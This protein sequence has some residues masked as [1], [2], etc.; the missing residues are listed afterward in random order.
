[1][2][3]RNKRRNISRSSKGGFLRKFF[4]FLLVLLI[5]TA[6]VAGFIL[7][8]TEKPTL[9]PTKKITYLGKRVELP[10]EASDFKS[11]L[12]SLEVTLEQKGKISRLFNRS[13]QR[14]SWFKDAGPKSMSETLVID[15]GGTGFDEGNASLVIRVRDFSLNGMFQGNETVHTIPVVI[16]TKAPKVS[17]IHSQQYIRPGS[18]GIVI[19]SVSE[20]SLRH[21][22]QIDDLFFQGFP[23][24]NA[25]NRFI[26]YIGLPWNS[27]E[28]QNSRVIAVDEAGNQGKSLVSMGFKPVA[29]K[30]DKINVGPGF[31]KRKIPE[32]EE[33]YPDMSGSKV[34]KFIHINNNIRKSNA[35]T[36]ADMCA[37]PVDKRLWS[38][39]FLRMPG[40]RKAGFAEQRTYFHN[41]TPIDHQTHLGIDLASTAHA[42]VRAANHGKVVFAGYLGIYGN[43]VLLDHGQG[44]FSLY[45]H[46]SSID[47]T[48]GLMVEKDEHLGNTGITGMAGGDHLHFS[49]LIHGVFVNPVEWWDQRWIDVNID[50]F[51]GTRAE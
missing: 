4:L 42:D 19:Y 51:A 36:I 24:N 8:E 3:R 14:R 43:M 34:E 1:M 37:N 30:T 2:A 33:Y 29:E 12:R 28:P 16:D 40:A 26:A 45:S 46:L 5:S 7:F 48:P 39:R 27:G 6:A 47:V 18:S 44:L 21:G 25:K 9:T 23:L 41:G 32:F 31:L 13:F 11:G 15:A 10:V 35:D 50:A 20:P 17:T 38:G 22:V 49:T